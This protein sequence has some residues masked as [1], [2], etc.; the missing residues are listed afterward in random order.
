MHATC[1]KGQLLRSLAKISFSLC[2][3]VGGS[4]SILDRKAATLNAQVS[5][6][7]CFTF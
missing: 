2:L 6:I 5:F 7:L 1:N 4:S 3:T